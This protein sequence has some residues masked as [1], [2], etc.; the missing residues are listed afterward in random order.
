MKKLYLLV[1]ALL[2]AWPAIAQ[3]D[4]VLT[5]TVLI[6]SGSKIIFAHS[7]IVPFD[8]IER[9]NKLI[10]PELARLAYIKG[11]VLNDEK[12]YVSFADWS[13]FFKIIIKNRHV[14]T[15]YNPQA[16]VVRQE[17]ILSPPKEKTNWFFTMA[18]ISCSLLP[19]LLASYRKRIYKIWSPRLKLMMALSL[20]VIG[21]A[22]FAVLF[23][24]VEAICWLIFFLYSLMATVMLA[25][26]LAGGLALV[27]LV[28]NNKS[29]IKEPTDSGQPMLNIIFCSL[30]IIL[31][32]IGSM[33]SWWVASSIALWVN[34]VFF[35]SRFVFC[36]EA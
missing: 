9:A 14:W 32:L 20:L 30:F 36:P 7:K 4:V 18:L 23:I 24:N 22:W 6:E 5:D 34:V 17:M 35:F 15:V 19:V 1:L 28:D 10:S 25:L 8:T 16:K 29:N 26:L 27:Q 12:T 31:V 2:L 33:T 13:K 3:T 21:F 11:Q